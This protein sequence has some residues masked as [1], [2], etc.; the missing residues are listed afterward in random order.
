MLFSGFVA[1]TGEGRLPRRVMFAE[2]LGDKVYSGEQ[3][4]DWMKDLEKDF[5]AFGIKCEGWREA[6]QKVGKWLRRTEEGAAV[7]MRK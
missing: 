2:M 7:L 3:E 1:R 6:A 5:K 4:W